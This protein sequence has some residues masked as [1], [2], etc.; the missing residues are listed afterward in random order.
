[1]VDT[2][3]PTFVICSLPE[4]RGKYY[5]AVVLLVLFSR[6]PNLAAEETATFFRGINLNGE[7]V[8]IDGQRWEGRDS[9]HY[10]CQDQA[11]ESQHVM[12]V[13]ATDSE[14]AKM[15]R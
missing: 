8:T 10:V 4:P 1:M 7:V 3:Y 14:R 11:F 2:S 15:I 13:P 5:A 6:S 12:L 9:S